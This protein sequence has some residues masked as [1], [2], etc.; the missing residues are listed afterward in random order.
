VRAVRSLLHPDDLAS[1]VAD[2]YE[3][4]A[5]VTVALLRLGFNDTYVVTDG[6]GGRWALRVY[7]NDKY[8][9]RS[10]SDLRCELELLEHLAL[11]GRP[12]VRPVRCC[13][14]DLLGRLTAP[15]GARCFALFGF[16]PGRSADDRTLDLNTRHALG[17]EIAR[18]HVAMDGF[19]SDRGRYHLDADLLVG[20]ALTELRAIGAEQSAAYGEYERLALLVKDY[21]A[22]LDQD[23]PAYGLIHADIHPGNVLLA[24]TGEFTLIDFDHCGFGWRAYDLTNFYVG[25]GASDDARKEWAALLDG[26]E[27]VRPFAP[28]E[29]DAIP[30]LTAC[31]GLWDA[32]D[33]LRAASWNGFD[34][35]AGTL[36]QQALD[37]IRKPLA[38]MNW[39]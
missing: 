5:P 14:G 23:G 34:G 35:D 25:P 16:V 2:E 15:E 22:G 3:V 1:L 13:S 20:M 21:L 18:L 8:W 26:Y 9:I 37:R 32:G 30:V 10:D 29:R 4:A 7:L 12:V 17:A 33:W 31:R 36:C 28:A 11:A 24:P 6:G 38:A 39:T 27:S 19:R